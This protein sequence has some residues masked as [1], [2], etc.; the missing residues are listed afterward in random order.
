[1]VQDGTH[2]TSTDCGAPEQPQLGAWH[3][4]WALPGGDPGLEWHLFPP[5]APPTPLLPAP[6]SL[7]V[8]LLFP[9]SVPSST[10]STGLLLSQSLQPQ[11]AVE[12]P[13]LQ[14]AGRLRATP[15]PLPP[16]IELKKCSKSQVDRA[17]PCTYPR[18][19]FGCSSSIQTCLWL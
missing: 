18:L 4:T 11:E 1:M 8:P 12:P 7:S 9:C 2:Q 10:L 15:A 13:S 19:V 16:F 14:S 17:L 5:P 6:I 3:S